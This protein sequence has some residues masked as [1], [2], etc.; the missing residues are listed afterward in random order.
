MGVES[1]MNAKGM[2]PLSGS[3]IPTTQHSV[4]RG[5]VEIACSIAPFLC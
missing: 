4:M 5:C 1:V 3:G 2:W